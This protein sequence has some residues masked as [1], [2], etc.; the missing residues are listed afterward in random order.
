MH[1]REICTVYKSKSFFLALQKY[2]EFYITYHHVKIASLASLCLSC[3]CVERQRVCRSV[4]LTQLKVP[5]SA[6]VHQSVSTQGTTTDVPRDTERAQAAGSTAGPL[7]RTVG[8][9]R[10]MLCQ[11]V[12]TSGA[13]AE[14]SLPLAAQVSEEKSA[15]LLRIQGEETG[16]GKAVLSDLR[17]RSPGIHPLFHRK[18][19][20]T[21]TH[22]GYDLKTE[23]EA[24]QKQRVYNNLRWYLKTTNQ[25]A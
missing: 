9:E 22:K 15:V 3:C 2:K 24:K 8:R 20:H 17:Q 14:F 25:S 6:D 23:T 18:V 11:K 16:I 19:S 21:L 12:G 10:D 1:Y 5:V 13:K 7:S 4:N